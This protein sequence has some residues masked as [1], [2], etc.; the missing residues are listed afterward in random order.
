MF[1]ITMEDLR[2]Q[3]IMAKIKDSKAIFQT[4]SAYVDKRSKSSKG[5]QA[6]SSA[7][8]LDM[9]RVDHNEIDLKFGGGSDHDAVQ[10]SR[11]QEKRIRNTFKK[12]YHLNTQR[13]LK[14]LGYTPTQADER[15]FLFSNY[16]QKL[17]RELKGEQTH[18]LLKPT[19]LDLMQSPDRRS[20]KS[21]MGSQDQSAIY[22]QHLMT[23][24]HEKTLMMGQGSIPRLQNTVLLF[25]HELSSMVQKLQPILEKMPSDSNMASDKYQE[26]IGKL[27]P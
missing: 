14:I 13:M 6:S 19:S 23:E 18:S 5:A 27:K 12:L 2:R 15:K 21:V 4:K 26:F 22:D 3:N 8:K 20:G 1:N 17:E 25:K 7:Q 24:M 9:Q 10:Q 11:M 16:K